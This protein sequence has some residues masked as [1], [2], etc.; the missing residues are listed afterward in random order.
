MFWFYLILSILAG[1]LLGIF[2]FGGLW[3][4]V[5]KI[6]AGNSKPYFLFLVSFIIRTVVVLAGFYLL[7][8]AGWQYLLSALAGF[9]IARTILASKLKPDRNIKHLRQNDAT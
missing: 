6:T 9:L 8:T 1:I 2:F 5:K 3:W 7:L 4:T